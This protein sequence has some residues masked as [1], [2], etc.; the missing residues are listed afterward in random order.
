[1]ECPDVHDAFDEGQHAEIDE[2]STVRN[3]DTGAELQGR[4]MPAKLMDLL[5]GW[6]IYPLL[7]QRGYRIVPSEAH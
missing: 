4:P 5:K 3:L 6:G 7:E 2:R 1:M